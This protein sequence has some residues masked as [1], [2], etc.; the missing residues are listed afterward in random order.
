MTTHT[1]LI[2]WYH[3]RSHIDDM[4]LDVYMVA[5]SN[6]IAASMIQKA[7]PEPI[8][9]SYLQSLGRV[10]SEMIRDKYTNIRIIEFL[11]DIFTDGENAI[12][13][14]DAPCFLPRSD[15]MTMH[16]PPQ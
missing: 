8:I 5:I 4:L 14:D 12:P 3:K 15:R 7:I 13:D 11:M 10:V 6:C 9:A 2:K 16:R 1:K